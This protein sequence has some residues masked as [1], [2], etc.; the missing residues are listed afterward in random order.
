MYKATCKL[1]D[2]YFDDELINDDVIYPIKP[3]LIPS[4]YIICDEGKYVPDLGPIFLQK[5]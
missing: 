4:R 2:G 3:T 1:Q 5:N